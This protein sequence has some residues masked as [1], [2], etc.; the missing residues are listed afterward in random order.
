MCSE[1]SNV[2]RLNSVRMIYRG[3][4]MGKVRM[5]RADV[6]RKRTCVTKYWEFKDRLVAQAKEQNFEL[7]DM[8]CIKFTIEMPKSWSKKKKLLMS[9]TPHQQKSDLDNMI[10]A[11]MDCLL[12]DDSTV[13]LIT[14]M[15]CWGES[16]EI[17]IYNLDSDILVRRNI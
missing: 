1:K 7:G 4:I 8:F 15:K 5:S 12:K 3:S 10:K 14:G 11:V 17:E 6:W 13:W 9:G 16:S 2:E